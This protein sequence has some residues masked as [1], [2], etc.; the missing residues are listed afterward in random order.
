ML[1][2]CK[3]L[4]MIFWFIRKVSTVASTIFTSSSTSFFSIHEYCIFC[5]GLSLASRS[6]LERAVRAF[7]I[8]RSSSSRILV[9]VS[10]TCRGTS[11]TSSNGS[12][13]MSNCICLASTWSYC[14]SSALFSS[15]SWRPAVL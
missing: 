6:N 4:S 10:R 2:F 3:W 9:R 12:M 11:P 8:R 7:M 5:D 14:I 15:W 13:N 1:L